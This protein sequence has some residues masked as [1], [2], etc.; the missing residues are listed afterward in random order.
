MSEYTDFWKSL[1]LPADQSQKAKDINLVSGNADKLS[2][3]DD[4]QYR[5]GWG[6]EAIPEDWVKA[7]AKEINDQ[8]N[9]ADSTAILKRGLDKAP[10]T[11]EE[12]DAEA[13][14]KALEDAKAKEAVN[15]PGAPAINNG[16]SGGDYG[17]PGAANA[18]VNT[19]NES[20]I[21]AAGKAAGIAEAASNVPGKIGVLGKIAG[22]LIGAVRDAQIGDISDQMSA[23]S[24][25]QEAGYAAQVNADGSVS[26]VSNQATTDA[27]DAAAF[28]TTSAQMDVDRAE[29]NSG[30]GGNTNS[31][32]GQ[33]SDSAAGGTGGGGTS[34]NAG[35]NSGD[36]EGCVDPAVPVLMAD[37]S[38]KP[39]GLLVVGDVLHT[40]HEGTLEFGPFVVSAMA[41][42]QQ[43]KRHIVFEDGPS[44]TASESHKFFT[45]DRQWVRV[46]DMSPGDVV[47]GIDGTFKVLS[48]DDAGH[49][50]VVKLT[51]EKAHTYL[52]AGLVSHNKLATG[53][54][55][56]AQR[57]SGPDPR[58][59]DDGYS[60]LDIGEFVVRKQ[61]V[62]YYG[63][64]VLKALNEG[65]IP[66]DALR[67]L[68]GK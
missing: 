35:S 60:A 5:L 32:G 58:G 50:D 53:G 1:D 65:R 14:A 67:R 54:Q 44:I 17:G 31:N 21:D 64:D 55:V 34:N 3:T 9:G 66:A 56:T 40:M 25:A 38:S 43:P 30:G 19:V 37:M 13:A 68:I 39:A 49:G 52:A 26:S 33:G 28:G 24:A 22:G 57:L 12:L 51:V 59:P 62:N 61:A 20:A 15:T 45:P 11:Q 18:S 46:V 41:I 7:R 29:S 6:D 8:I 2:L 16:G 10:K 36:G 23:I 48:I 4:E 63:S 47:T 42:V 27:Q